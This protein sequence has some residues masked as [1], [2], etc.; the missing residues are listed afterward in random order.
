MLGFVY[1]SLLKEV[2]IMGVDKNTS[3]GN[4]NISLDA[5]ASVASNAVMNVFGVVGLAKKKSISDDINVFLNKERSNE[6]VVV[7]KDR[8]RYTIDL[9]IVLAYGA[10]VSEVILEVQ[11]QVKYFLDKAFD[12]RFDTVNV[13]VQ[14]VKRI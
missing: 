4:I 3:Y 5:I 11:R 6:G 12:L 2:R 1:F 8:N 9:Y 10:K 14:G 13:F 7:K